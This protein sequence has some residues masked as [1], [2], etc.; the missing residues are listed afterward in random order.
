LL[1]DQIQ[2]LTDSEGLEFVREWDKTKISMVVLTPAVI[3]LMFISIW[4]PV[5]LHFGQDSQAVVSTAFTTGSYVV[6]VGTSCLTS[7]SWF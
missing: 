2:N 6:T 5:F 1:T 4:I 3:S 7:D